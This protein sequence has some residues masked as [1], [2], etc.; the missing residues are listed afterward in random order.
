M[1]S[2][3]FIH[4]STYNQ[5]FFMVFISICSIFVKLCNIGLPFSSNCTDSCSCTFKH[6]LK[7][8]HNFFRGGGGKS[9]CILSQFFMS[10]LPQGRVGSALI[11]Q[12]SQILVFFFL[13]PS[14]SLDPSHR[15]QVKKDENTLA[16]NFI[17]FIWI[18]TRCCRSLFW[19]WSA[20]KR[21]DCWSKK[22]G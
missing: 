9:F 4:F 7:K 19:C 6:L 3:L 17:K 2:P 13:H 14:L 22:S 18:W 20:T 16:N 1:F 11:W 10:Q 5:C 15:S 12:M 8:C 21:I